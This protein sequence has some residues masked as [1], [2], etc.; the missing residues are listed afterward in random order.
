MIVDDDEVIEQIKKRIDAGDK[1]AVY[2]LGRGY[3]KGHCG[4]PRDE[5]KALELFEKAGELGVLLPILISVIIIYVDKEWKGMYR[6]LK[7]ASG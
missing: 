7:S 1:E 2:Q 4:L 5:K 6:K 3:E